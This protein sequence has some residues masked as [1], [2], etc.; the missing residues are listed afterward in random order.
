METSMCLASCWLVLPREMFSFETIEVAK[1]KVVHATYCD[2]V[3][4]SHFDALHEAV[5]KFTDIQ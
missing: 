3:I 5:Y 2:V 4:R 1:R